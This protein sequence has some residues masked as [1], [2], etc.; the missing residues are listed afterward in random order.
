MK[1]GYIGAAKLRPASTYTEREGWSGGQILAYDYCL[2]A[3][4]GTAVIF[5]EGYICFL[6]VASLLRYTER[7][8]ALEKEK[9]KLRSVYTELRR[10]SE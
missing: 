6:V 9:T 10:I 3:P 1:E 2:S 7:C 8:E 4:D 5:K